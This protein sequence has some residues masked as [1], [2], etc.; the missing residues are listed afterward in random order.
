MTHNLAS[1]RIAILAKKPL[2]RLGMVKYVRDLQLGHR[3]IPSSSSFLRLPQI[4]SNASI[5]T[6]IAELSGSL[7]EMKNSVRQL[8]M[9]SEHFPKLSIVVYTACQDIAVLMPLIAHKQLSLI[10][11]QEHHD[12]IRYDMHLALMGCKVCSPKIKKFVESVKKNRLP[13][14]ETLT[15]SERKVLLLI[16][17][18][19]SQQDI[20]TLHNRSA[21]T[22]SA[23][24]RSCMRKLGVYNDAE[25]FTLAKSSI[26]YQSYLNDCTQQA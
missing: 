3:Y 22:I 26:L 8:L 13:G 10:S 1:T 6:L 14:L 25:L 18:G 11:S 20:A 19:M 12:Q 7:E 17:S 21:K 5:N 4:I 9:L 2:F 16:F 24:K 23:Q 15:D